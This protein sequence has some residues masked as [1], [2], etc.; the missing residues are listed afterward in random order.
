LFEMVDE[1]TAM[2]VHPSNAA[3][4]DAWNGDQGALWVTRAERLE[5]GVAG[6]RDEFFAAAGIDATA[7]VLDIG[8]GNGRSTVDAARRATDGSALGVDLS[9]PMIEFARRVAERERLTN[10]AFQQADAQ[11]HVFPESAFDIAISRN[12]AMFFGDAHAAFT[13]IARALRPGGRLVLQAWQA[14]HRN[15]WISTFRSTF[16]AGRELPTPPA[17]GPGP[18][19]LSDPDRV[20]ELLAAAGFTD[21]RLRDLHAPMYF[22]RDVDDAGEFIV[23]Q[24]GGTLAGLDPDARTHALAELRAS[25]ADHLTAQ[26]VRYDSAAWLVE[27]RRG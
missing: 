22:G 24:F 16:S 19:S 4:A 27:A 7:R 5:E 1:S 11:I 9:L 14:L 2:R 6:Y 15:E 20:R 12:G 25:L 13:N 26:G 23:D 3:Q 10:V 21:I 18:F 8:C 17:D